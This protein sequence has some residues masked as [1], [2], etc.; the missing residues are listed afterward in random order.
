MC[1]T[2]EI[3]GEVNLRGGGP[4]VREVLAGTGL[5]SAADG[6]QHFR[7]ERGRRITYISRLQ[8][9]QAA[10]ATQIESLAKSA[11]NKRVAI[12]AFSSGLQLHGDASTDFDAAAMA[13]EGDHLESCEELRAAGQAAASRG[14]VSYQAVSAASEGLIERL[15]TLEEGGGTA[16]GPA[17]CVALGMAQGVAGSKVIVCTDGLANIGVGALDELDTDAATEQATAFYAALGNRAQAQGCS[18]DVV[19]LEGDGC[20]V[21]NLGVMSEA[22]G[23][24]V[25][26]L[27]PTKLVDEF[28]AILAEPV[29][30]T[31][32]TLTMHLHAGLRFRN[33]DE[34]VEE[35]AAAASTSAPQHHH[36]L[37]KQIGNVTASS[38]VSVEFG[39]APQRATVGTEL[40]FQSQLR[41][42][43]ADGSVV[44]RVQTAVM[45]V[46]QDSALA[47]AQANPA[48]LAAHAAKQTAQLGQRGDYM[49]AR[50]N[51]FA[52]DGVLQRCCVEGSK[53]RTYSSWRGQQTSLDRRLRD[54]QMEEAMSGIGDLDAMVERSARS[55]SSAE[56]MA[57]KSARSFHRRKARSKKDHFSAELLQVKASKSTTY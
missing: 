16:L 52:Y 55:G 9:V 48:L 28:A 4:D 34:L 51:S 43:R 10:V 29:L 57:A 23:G 45:P 11:P 36:V 39:L 17:I 49:A 13:V 8:A 44:T 5:L 40:P 46:T 41:F 42:T 19:A 6:P 50:V 33:E 32:C 56:L 37:V 24:T 12:V 31:R 2:S 22:A 21:E 7:S 54:E 3:E 26:K 14:G 38:E 20:D 1:V 18:I 27:D 53:Q 15:Y 35:A 30:A 25:S 47:E